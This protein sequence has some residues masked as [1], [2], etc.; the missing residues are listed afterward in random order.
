M[1]SQ[2]DKT[3]TVVVP[4]LESQPTDDKIEVGGP[5]RLD[6][7]EHQLPITIQVM[8]AQTPEAKAGVTDEERFKHSNAKIARGVVVLNRGD[9][10]VGDPKAR[11]DLTLT[12]PA[13]DFRDGEARGIAVAV[14]ANPDEFAYETLT[15]CSHIMLKVEEAAGY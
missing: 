12:V 9:V 11:W 15:W 1:L 8:V 3:G 2:F 13:G 7:K 14:V 6:P 5:L 10:V 4:P